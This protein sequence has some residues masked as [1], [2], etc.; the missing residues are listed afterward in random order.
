MISEKDFKNITILFAEDD[1]TVLENI[2]YSLRSY[3][4]EVYI[5]KDGL[6][7][8]ELYELYSPNIILT[9]IRMPKLS[10]IEL[11][12]KI[13]KQDTQT[14]VVMLSAHSDK[15][16]LLDV[17][18]LYLEN[19]LIKPISHTK[20]ITVLTR[21]VEKYLDCNQADEVL[22]QDVRYSFKSK[23]IVNDTQ[24]IPLTNQE[25]LLLELL[26]K[27][28]GAAVSYAEIEEMVW[29]CELMTKDAIKTLVKK[30][31]NKLP[32]GS[33]VNIVDFGYKLKC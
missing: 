1:E 32:E 12:Q 30:L 29:K 15:E 3:F 18:Q 5:A 6:E 33:I 20:L 14:L 23:E 17:V 4:K 21:C 28:K 10:G 26:I 19:Y 16:I 31:R 8:W 9:D 11:V 24:T 7:A 25:I 27:H 22:S 13:R 2:G